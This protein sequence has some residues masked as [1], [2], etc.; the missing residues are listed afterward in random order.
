MGK[1]RKQ[2]TQRI[3]N[4][5]LEIL[6]LLTGEDYT[7]V[8]K[9]G[10][11][12]PHC[13]SPNPC[14]SKE[15]NGT[16]NRNLQPLV[17]NE[18]HEKMI[19]ERTNKILNPLIE[20]VPVRCE[21]VAVY[22]SVE[23]WEYLEGHKELYTGVVHHRPQTSLDATGSKSPRDDPST[24][25]SPNG[26]DPVEDVTNKNKREAEFPGCSGR[27]KRQRKC[28]KTVS[29]ESSS[30]EGDL[31]DSV[32][33]KSPAHGEAADSVL[34]NVSRQS[35]QAREDSASC[36]EPNLEDTQTSTSTQQIKTVYVSL[37]HQD[38]PGPSDEHIIEI[39]A[40]TST[41]C[42]AASVRGDGATCNENVIDVE[43]YVPAGLP[44]RGYMTKPIKEESRPCEESTAADHKSYSPPAHRTTGRVMHGQRESEL[45][46]CEDGTLSDTEMY[47]QREQAEAPHTS[48][49]IKEESASCDEGNLSDVDIYTVTEQTGYTTAHIVRNRNMA[50]PNNLYGLKYKELDD[51]FHS[52]SPSTSYD[53][54]HSTDMIYEC[55]WCHECFTRYSE[56]MKHQ[57]AHRDSDYRNFIHY[58]ADF[59]KEQS[60]SPEE[61]QFL[62]TDCGKSFLSKSDL[63]KH[64]RVHLAD[65]PYICSY[66]GKCF[67]KNSHLIRHQRIHTGEKPYVCSYCGKCFTKNSHLVRHQRIHTGEKPFACSDCGKG[68]TNKSNLITH[69]RIHTGEKPY[70]C[71]VCGKCF[72]GKSDLNRHIKIHSGEKPFICFECGNSFGR[73]TQLNS[74]LKTHIREKTISSLIMGNCQM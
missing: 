44:H 55:S 17:E 72:G 57:I 54:M 25:T 11:N 19:L 9:S 12:V 18:T 63:H 1:D 74:H 46:S 53:M 34:S 62:C 10:N 68:F 27:R 5:T 66:C 36:A 24:V 56:F 38:K 59:G 71:V 30:C 61:K 6:Y 40:S 51:Q 37:P 31:T 23:E 52:H 22:F 2:V 41:E 29:E 45:V 42:L 73:K 8:K 43:R 15:S 16:Q 35:T 13:S 67:S 70:S 4:L 7:V 28:M 20:E 50:K 39:E 26:K 60:I 49:Y 33:N 58:E 47:T 69:Q 14:V 64:D 65:R 21:D 3:V 32:L 48:I